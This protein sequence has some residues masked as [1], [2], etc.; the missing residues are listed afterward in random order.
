MI[1]ITGA[2]GFIG[3]H[4][5]RHFKL[6]GVDFIPLD[7]RSRG[8]NYIDVRDYGSV[9]RSLGD[10]DA[11]IHLAALIDARESSSRWK[12]YYETNITGTFNVAKFCRDNGMNMVFA[13]SAAVYGAPQARATES[14][15]ANPLNFYGY[16]KWIGEELIRK[17]L[18]RYVIL[19]LSNVYGPECHGL[20][21][22]LTERDGI[23][24]NGDGNQKRDFVYIDDV[25]SAFQAA[26]STDFSGTL[27]IGSGKS[28]TV[29][30][31]VG[32]AENIFGKSYAKTFRETNEVKLEYDFVVEKAKSALGWAPRYS[33]REGLKK[34]IF[35]TPQNLQ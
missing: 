16:T 13:S 15:P 5:C 9:E 32:I 31:A 21:R 27:N 28:I 26:V 24:I 33:F 17:L 7:I 4:I 8:R 29:N 30:E 35:S 25:V 11:V 22:V 19:R 14:T 34:M 3:S 18:D 23:V 2:S 1:G 6:L 10:C 12:D 20:V